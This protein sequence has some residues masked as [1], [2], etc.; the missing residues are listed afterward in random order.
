MSFSSRRCAKRRWNKV[1]RCAS[2]I[3]RTCILSMRW[4]QQVYKVLALERFQPCIQRALDLLFPPQCAACKR[5]GS[6]LCP[7]CLTAIQP[8]PGPYCQHCHTQLS[9]EGVCDQCRYRP[10]RMSGLRVVSAYRE[11]LRACIHALKYG[12]N[13]RLAEPLG[14]LLAQAYL[15]YSLQSDTIIPVPL[16]RERERERGY[17]QSH[18]LAR[19]CS[20]QLGLPLNSNTVMRIRPTQAQAHLPASERQRNVA[21]A[22]CCVPAFATEALYGRRILLVDDVCTTGATLEACAAPLFAAG[23]ASVWGLVL[24]RPIR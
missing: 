20:A 23:A 19:V 10:L 14:A 21:G 13:R 12:G 1:C 22:F 15:V 9:S 7:S 3:R 6:V 5:G 4:S 16:H 18:L 11:P 24:A 8:L 2:G 17:N